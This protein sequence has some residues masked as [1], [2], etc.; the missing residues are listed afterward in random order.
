MREESVDQKERRRKD[1]VL[2]EK[3]LV[4]WYI[5][6]RSSRR[7]SD[8]MNSWRPVRNSEKNFGDYLS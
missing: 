2:K 5:L 4:D 1:T 3:I 6:M 7:T 8:R